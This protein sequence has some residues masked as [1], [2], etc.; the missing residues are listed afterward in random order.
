MWHDAIAQK[1]SPDPT[2]LYGHTPPTPEDILISKEYSESVAQGQRCPD[3]TWELA[4][5]ILLIR[6]VK[7][8]A[9]RVLQDLTFAQIGEAM[10]FS[11]QRAH[12]LHT[13]AVRK[14]RDNPP[15]A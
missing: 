5:D 13:D 6:E 12:K 11:A 10:G 9:L 4:Q 8:L 3:L 1:W 7:V 14:L 2:W 15:K